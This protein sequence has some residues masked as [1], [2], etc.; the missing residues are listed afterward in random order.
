M[1]APSLTRNT[2]Y[3]IAGQG[4]AI[5]I[6]VAVLPITIHALGDARFGLLGLAWALLG[7]VGALDL[8][9]GRATTQFVAQ[10]LGTGATGDDARLRRIATL[11]IVSQVAIGVIASAAV[12]LLAP[13][14][15]AL[16]RVAAPLRAEAQAM[17]VALALSIPLVML[18]AGLR[19]V[20]EAAQ[21]FDI[22]NLIRTPASAA[23]FVVPAVAAPLGASLPAIV[24]MLAG[25]R[26]AA[27]VASALAIRR[28]IPGFRWELRLQWPA[29][30]AL[31]GYGGWV[32]V[33]SVVGPVLVYLE[34]FL[35]AAIV[36]VAAV[37]YYTAPA[38]VAM[39]L[40]IV[41]AGLASALFPAVTS[42]GIP[43]VGRY[44]A[45]PLR[46]L[47]LALVPVVLL[48]AV[49]AHPLLAWWL[50]AEYAA[51]GAAAF[52]ILAVGVLI[53]G[54]GHVP[55]AYLLGR[56]RPDLPAKFHLLELPLYVAAAWLLI[57]GYGVTGAALAWT[58]RVTLDAALLGA[59]V[60]REQPLRRAAH[61]APG[62]GG[63]SPQHLP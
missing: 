12:A 40:L 57:R 33:S 19:A 43:A 49:F 27:C 20:L 17:T 6:G 10:L 50:G 2:L 25:V 34:R 9:L 23:I 5:V 22:V 37:G 60:W 4:S 36:G 59:A 35:L 30:R 39:R 15:V 47:A 42:A 38:E 26:V 18:A 8:G 45:R 53:N 28:V 21:R 56:G 54:L 14:L 3:N 44:V 62:Q 29:L 24:L 58:L 31:L 48:V 63:L 46:M 16:L 32:T 61:H 1:P 7:Y 52:S 11:S 55:Y 13:H 51:Q 41:P